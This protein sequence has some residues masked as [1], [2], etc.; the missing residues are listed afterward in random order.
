MQILPSQLS[1]AASAALPIQSN[2]ETAARMGANAAPANA[3]GVEHVEHGE[4]TQD[5][6]ANEQYVGGRRG[7]Q[8]NQ[9]GDSEET[10]NGANSLLHLAARD[11]DLPSTLDLIG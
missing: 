5:R 8:Q 11:D 3:A 10:A 4:Q 6:D 1:T 9:E 7:P 2:R